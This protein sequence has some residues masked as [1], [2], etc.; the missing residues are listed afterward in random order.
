MTTDHITP[1]GTSVLDD[2]GLDAEFTAKAKLAIR[3]RKTI[4]ELGLTQRQVQSRTGLPQPRI[5]QIVRGQL[6]DVSKTKLE[7]C[8]RSLGHDITIMI[9]PRHEGSG[10]L[11]VL[12]REAA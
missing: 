8:L 9:G 6:D 7:E 11:K 4:E 1:A 3:I 10:E 5:S 12:T 2:L